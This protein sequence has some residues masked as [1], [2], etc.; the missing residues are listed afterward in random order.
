MSLEHAILGFLQYRPMS[1]YSLKKVFDKSVRHFWP[2]DQ[3][4]IYRTLARLAQQG[5][6]MPEVVEQED[7]PDRKVYHITDAGRAELHRWLTAPLPPQDVRSPALI[8]VFFAGRLS[9]AEALAIFEREAE[10]LRCTLA[11]YRQIPPDP[12]AYA[13]I[14]ASARD[15]AFWLLTLEAGIRGAEANLAWIEDVITRLKSNSVPLPEEKCNHG[16]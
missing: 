12:G 11:A 8:Q 3:G 1:G 14:P 13:D 15:F 10:K 4:H 2:A 6:A 5:W 9:Q 7:R 16:Q